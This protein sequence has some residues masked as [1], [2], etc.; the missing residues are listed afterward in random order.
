MTRFLKSDANPNGRR[1]EDILIELRADVLYR[2][3]KISD[4]TRPEALHVL[5]NNVKVLDH[6]TQA[7]ELAHDSTHLLAR[8]F[9]PSEAEQGGP[10]RI[11]DA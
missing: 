3:T 1:L 5:A 10:P 4:D 2:C 9:G 7:I 11:G 8:A 6:L